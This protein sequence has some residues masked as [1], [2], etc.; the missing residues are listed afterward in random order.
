MIT[1]LL[2]VVFAACLLACEPNS[3]TEMQSPVNQIPK[4]AEEPMPEKRPHEMTL[5]G[6][7]RVDEYYW[8]R[9]DSRSDPDVLAYLNEENAYFN[10]VMEPLAGL[11]K[12]L[13]EEITARINPD[14]SGVPYERDGYWYYYRYEPGSEY[15]IHARRKGNMEAQEEILIDENERAQGHKFYNLRAMAVSEDHRYVAIAE[16]TTGRRIN[17]IRFLNTVT[18]EYLAEQIGNASNAL[19]FSSDGQYLFYH[20]LDLQT[21]LDSEVMRHKLGTNASEDVLVYKELDNTF[22]SWVFTSRSRDY[23]FLFLQS[24]NSTEV[25]WLAA[26]DPM[27]EF[28]PFLPREADHEYSIDH[29]DG[30]FFIRTNWQAENFRLMSSS[31]E[32]S[33]D[34]SKWQELIPHRHDELLLDVQ[35]FDKWLVLSERVNGIQQVRVLAHDGTVDR[36]LQSEEEAYVMWPAFNA[37]TSASKIRYG[38]SS[39]TTPNQI[40]EVDLKSGQ[41]TLLKADL[42][43]GGFRS[44]DYRT[45]R[46]NITARDGEEVPVTMTWHKESGPSE[47][48]PAL[49]YAYGSYGSP[50]DPWFDRNVIS[51][52]DRG[53][54]YVI[55]HIRGGDEKGRRWYKQG[56][57]LNKKNTFYDFIDV[58]KQLQEKKLI[59]SERTYANGVSAGGLLMGAVLNMAPELYNGAIVDVPFVDVITTMLDDTI[60]LTSGEWN[61]WGNPMIKEQYDYMLSYSPY[62]QIKQQDYPNLFVIT[63]FED[64]QVQYYEPAKWVARLRDRRTD[65]NKLIFQIS[66]DAGHGGVSGRYRQRMEAAQSF[67]FIIDLAGIEK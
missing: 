14:D 57:M 6:D 23:I 56:R 18:G 27:G 11:Q 21:L 67:A 64:S 7:T 9:D 55:A 25:R 19:A 4:P 10:K 39:M 44:D 66:M 29:A 61:E 54:V 24:T 59:D 65:N 60:P 13:F 53:F 26:D 12:T 49:I 34:K 62:D 15:A 63:A 58:T 42:V 50:S 32:H 37:S 33:S 20:N 22:Y 48:T 47:S 28:K 35:A 30:R 8:L 2:M 51:L 1:R 36:Y 40:W 52:L 45:K 16:D 41:S 3:R 38:F 43:P 17:Q 31:I 46:I 5:H